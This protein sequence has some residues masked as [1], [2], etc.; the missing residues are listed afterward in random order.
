ML[1]AL[2]MMVAGSGVK[3]ISLEGTWCNGKG[4]QMVLK[5]A[6][7]DGNDVTG[8]YRTGVGNAGGWYEIRGRRT[9]NDDGSQ[10]LAFAVAWANKE[11]GNSHS[12]T[13]WSGQLQM[14]SGRPTITALWL[15]TRQTESG[16]NWQS[17]RIDKVTFTRCDEP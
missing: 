4:S 17:T 14:I 8:V 5:T 6:G 12:A 13:A 1:V 15:L 7:V 9:V 10:V 11:K 2:L 3:T 16:E